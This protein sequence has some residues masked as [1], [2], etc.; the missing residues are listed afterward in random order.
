MRQA[1]GDHGHAI[2]QDSFLDLVT[3]LVGILIILV[4][5]M[6]LRIKNMP[7]QN[8]RDE[9][10]EAANSALA[11]DQ[12]AEQSLRQDVAR[13]AEQV[14]SLTAE[15]AVRNQERMT[16]AT[17][18][19]AGEH[20]I[21]A[22][23]S[24]LDEPSQE[25]FDLQR[26]IAEDRRKLDEL[27]RQRIGLETAAPDRV[28][29]LNYP[30]PLSKTIDGLEAHLQL[31][32]GRVVY[33]PWERFERMTHDDARPKVDKIFNHDMEEFTETIGPDSG[34]RIRYTVQRVERTEE[35]PRGPARVTSA[36]I[37]HWELIPTGA[38]LG[39][40]VEAALAENSELHRTLDSLS[41]RPSAVTIWFYRDGVAAFRELRKDL[42]KRGFVVA[43][44][45][46]FEGHFI[47]ASSKG[48]KSAGE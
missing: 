29:V 22:A 8:E 18:V 41:P 13:T 37:A 24:K 16:L 42:H 35:T 7:P 45:P 4:M 43:A 9:V 38:E 15:A 27:E 17:M 33:I 3:N 47:G 5:V 1:A 28:V 26:K 31:R 21:Q 6:G 39:E 34:F 11:Q 12:A 48:S 23:R 36:A 30:T 2:G 40:P 44:R 20:Q 14:R 25:D 10:F 46:L 19:A 32:A